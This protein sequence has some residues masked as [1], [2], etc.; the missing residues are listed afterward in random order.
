MQYYLRIIE[1]NEEAIIKCESFQDAL[2][3]RNAFINYNASLII[4]IETED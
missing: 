1:N 3:T 2:N 4:Y